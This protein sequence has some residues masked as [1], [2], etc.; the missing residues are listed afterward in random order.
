MGPC[1]SVVLVHCPVLIR[2]PAH[3]MWLVQGLDFFSYA[4]D[5]DCKILACS[6]F[7]LMVRKNASF[8]LM[9]RKKQIFP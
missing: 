6:S 9:L 1:L 7:L 2:S 4:T 3:L 8:S 5:W